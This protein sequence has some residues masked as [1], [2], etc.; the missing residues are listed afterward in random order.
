MGKM[1]KAV[2]ALA[3]ALI[4]GLYVASRYTTPE[5]EEAITDI[6]IRTSFCAAI[7]MSAYRDT[8]KA[9]GIG[10]NYMLLK[11]FAKEYNLSDTIE[12]CPRGESRIDSLLTGAIDILVLP[13]ND[14]L[15]IE[16]VL[17]SSP[18]DSISVWVVRSDGSQLLN[19]I[20]TWLEQSETSGRFLP[21][22]DKY[23]KHLSPY[24]TGRRDWISPYDSLIKV[25]AA[26]IGWDWH[27]LAA[28]IYTESRFHIEA[29]SPRGATGLMQ[30]M[31]KMAAKMGFEEIV[32]PEE[33]I[34]AGTKL[35]GRL[36]ARYRDI[37]ADRVET[38]KFALAAYNAGI[39]HIQDCIT[40]AQSKGIEPRFWDDILLIMPEM[41]DSTILENEAI[42]LGTFNGSETTL[43]VSS[44]TS[45]SELFQNI[46]Q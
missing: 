42:R 25:N 30:L 24:K 40:Y 22:K 36:T 37:A 19:E 17:T 28:V 4:A 21:V 35:L 46:C 13:F 38:E 2:L 33:S 34:A 15:Q 41:R 31:P 27:T 6:E 11:E 43:F 14:S 20:D 1:D 12:L 39:G 7:E 29:I 18:I 26:K 44:V 45:V 23:L 32:D 10:Y 5:P 9:L 16:G 8:S 3:L